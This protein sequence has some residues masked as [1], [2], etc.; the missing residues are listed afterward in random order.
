[1]YPLKEDEVDN[2]ED[3]SAYSECDKLGKNIVC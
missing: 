1:M 2:A 3:N